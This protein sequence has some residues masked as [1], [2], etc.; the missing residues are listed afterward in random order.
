MEMEEEQTS[1][2]VQETS[3]L[4]GKKP[5]MNYVLAV[6]TQFNNGAKSV[7]IKARGNAISRAVDV[8]EI[9]K[10]RFF[11]DLKNPSKDCISI[12]TEEISNEDGTTSKVSAIQLLLKGA[13]ADGT[14]PTQNNT[15]FVGKKPTMNY[16]LAVVTQFNGGA[17]S[18]LV[19]ARG[20]SI[21]K[22][23]DIAEI[24]KNKFVQAIRSPSTDSIVINSEE[25]INEDGTKSKVSSI[26][27]TLEKG[28]NGA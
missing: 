19:K 13:D 2:T 17:K 16:V 3:V 14:E 28:S 23:V 12:S 1:S 25:L 6:V 22:A 21:S 20:N 7:R 18:V 26:A 10:S 27:I 24:T 9:V 4:V 5:A 15:V 11:T 8:A